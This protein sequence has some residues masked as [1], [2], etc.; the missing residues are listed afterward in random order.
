MWFPATMTGPSGGM[1]SV[2]S[3]R[4]LNQSVM[5]GR[6]VHSARLN[7]GSNAAI[8]PPDRAPVAPRGVRSGPPREPPPRRGYPKPAMRVL[9]VPVKRLERSKSRLSSLLTPVERAVL[10]LAM[11]EDVLDAALDQPG[12]EVWLVSKDEAA[13]E[14]GARRGARPFVEAGSSLL[15]AVRQVEAEV[16]GTTSSLAVLLADLPLITTSAL[17]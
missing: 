5:G 14:V 15:S 2:P 7:Q 10:T 17:A 9:A 16:P 4:Q 3:N 6:S 13:L 8:R 11:L 1:C 12:W